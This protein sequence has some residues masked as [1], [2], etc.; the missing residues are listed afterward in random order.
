MIQLEEIFKNWFDDITITPERLK[1]FAQDH[2]SRLTANNP[3]SV[4]TPIIT[5]TNTRISE[6]DAAITARASDAG[7]QT[8][9]V[10]TKDTARK[11]YQ[12]YISRKEGLIKSTFGK[13]SAVY[14]EFFPQGLSAFHKATDEEFL[15]LAQTAVEKA[16]TYETELGAT[17]KTEL[18]ALFN[19]YKNALEAVVLDKGETSDAQT[20]ERLAAYNLQIQLVTN[21]HTVALQNVEQ[22]ELALTYF[23]QSLLFAQQRK[24]IYKGGLAANESK[25]ACTFE[26]GTGKSFRIKNKGAQAFTVQMKFNG[27]LVGNAFTVQSGKELEKTFPD[28][29]TVGNALQITSTGTLPGEYQVE[30][31]A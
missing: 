2:V 22:G 12:D 7:A 26:Y 8:G 28:F 18:T 11:N 10:Y 9:S 31:F 17:F 5:A 6:L 20:D 24:H 13:P 14:N 30:E 4:Y 23:N 29:Y 27:V 15:N 3:G 25:E 1:A 16:T 19:A 21:V